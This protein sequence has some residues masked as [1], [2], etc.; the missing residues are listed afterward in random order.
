MAQII[1]DIS[2]PNDGLG[3]PLRDG[4][5]HQNQMNTELYSTKVDKILGKDL[6]SED[7]TSVEKAKLAGI[8]AGA[9]VNAPILWEDIVGVPAELNNSVGY[10]YYD[11]TITALSFS[12]ATEL[13]LPYKGRFY[14]LQNDIQ[15]RINVV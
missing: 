13:F 15:L 9:Q 2:M 6:S 4:F 10:F 3:D 7:F 11:N 5:D 1:H 8:E 14:R 12:A